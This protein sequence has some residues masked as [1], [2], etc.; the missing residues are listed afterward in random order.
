VDVDAVIVRH[1]EVAALG[2]GVGWFGG[3]GGGG[4]GVLGWGEVEG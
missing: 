3:G 4:V 1:E 2:G